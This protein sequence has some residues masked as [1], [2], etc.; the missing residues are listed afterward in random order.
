MIKGFFYETKLG[1]IGIAEE[2]SEIVMLCFGKNLPAD[3]EIIETEILKTAYNQLTEYLSGAR[4]SF[5]LPL[6]YNGTDF[7]KAVWSGLL[8][9][10]YGKTLSYGELAIVLNKPSAARA[11]GNAVN[12]N[13][14][15]IFIPCH[16]LIGSNKKLVGYAGG[17]DV[18]RKLLELEG[19]I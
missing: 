19:F 10:T 17:L 1:T 14:L 3:T 16:R 13:P 8:N 12:K 4:Q 5:D 15:L 9:I 7:Q 11:V 18:K 6:K 2:N